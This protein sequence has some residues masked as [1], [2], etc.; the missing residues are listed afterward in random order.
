MGINPRFIQPKYLDARVVKSDS[1]EFVGEG[2]GKCN[3]Y[4]FYF[5]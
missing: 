2:F 5:V 4:V 3:S 1:R